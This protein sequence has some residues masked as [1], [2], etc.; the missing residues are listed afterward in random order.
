M[1]KAAE[2]C[3]IWIGFRSA[4]FSYA[5]TRD[6]NKILKAGETT[7]GYPAEREGTPRIDPPPD[8]Q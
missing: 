8:H 6:T 4:V 5:A 1:S 3:A 2:H 7:P